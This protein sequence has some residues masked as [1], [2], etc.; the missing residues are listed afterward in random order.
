MIFPQNSLASFMDRSKLST[1]G[2]HSEVRVQIENGNISTGQTCNRDSQAAL[3]GTCCSKI[4]SP[5]FFECAVVLEILTRT[6]REVSL[7]WLSGLF[8]IGG[9]KRA[10]EHACI[11]IPRNKKETISVL[12]NSIGQTMDKRWEN[13]TGCRQANSS[14]LLAATTNWVISNNRN[15]NNLLLEVSRVPRGGR[16]RLPHFGTM[17]VKWS[18]DKRLK[19]KNIHSFIKETLRANINWSCGRSRRKAMRDGTG[20]WVLSG[21]AKN[22][23]YGFLVTL[24]SLL[25]HTVLANSYYA[26]ILFEVS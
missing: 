7:I 22:F 18:R 11:T 13:I 4:I 20:R 8:D 1:K 9:N 15:A 26:P 12:N 16:H 24:R 19:W 6:I 10:D 14:R 25:R 5:R 17:R 2:I 23:E 21:W 3:K